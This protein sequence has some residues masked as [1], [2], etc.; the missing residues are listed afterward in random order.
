MKVL[1]VVDMQNDFISG[2]LGTDEAQGIVSKVVNR[3]ADSRGELI[4]FTQDTHGADYLGT[5]EGRRLPVLHC[6]EG[7]AGWEIHHDVMLAWRA[8]ADTIIDTTLKYNTFKKPIFGS[9]ELVCYLKTRENEIESIEILGL[10]TDICVVSNA[11]MIKNTLPDI[12]IALNA[13]CCA[14]VTA[15]SHVEAINTMRMCQ[16]DVI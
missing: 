8:H 15:Q 2:T 1:I 6:I 14:G 16:I 4:L 7:T 13:A 11:I 3:I 10:C 9:S 12:P 5:P